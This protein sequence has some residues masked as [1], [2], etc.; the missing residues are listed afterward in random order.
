MQIQS[1]VHDGDKTIDNHLQNELLY[2]L[3]KLCVPKC[4]QLQLITE[5]HTT[6]VVGHFVGGKT[7]TNLKRYVYWPK[8]QEHVT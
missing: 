4:E 8:M 1:H 6:K 3:G 5:A 7:M 2:R